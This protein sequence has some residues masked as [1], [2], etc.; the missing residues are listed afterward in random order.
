MN[1]LSDKEKYEYLLS[2]LQKIRDYD[3]IDEQGYLDEWTEAASFTACQQI[4]EDA[5]KFI[6]EME[7]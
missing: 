7:S 3:V 5:L 1:V 2:I 6:E 4:A